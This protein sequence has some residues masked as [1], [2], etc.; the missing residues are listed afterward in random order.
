[1][2][3]SMKTLQTLMLRRLRRLGLRQSSG[4]FGFR[5]Q[6]HPRG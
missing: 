2:I 4:A 3:A 1:M 6:E 5:T